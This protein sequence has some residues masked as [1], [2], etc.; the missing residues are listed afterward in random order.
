MSGDQRYYTGDPPPMYPHYPP[1][2]GG[3]FNSI[4]EADRT[5]ALEKLANAI[6]R[7]CD[8]LEKK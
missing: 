5:A 7:L 8:A 1:L 4:L 3:G 6:N 2:G